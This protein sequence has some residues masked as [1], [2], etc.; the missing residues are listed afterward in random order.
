[1]AQPTRFVF[2][3]LFYTVPFDDKLSP[4]Q[5]LLDGKIEKYAVHSCCLCIYLSLNKRHILLPLLDIQTSLRSCV[6]NIKAIHAFEGRCT[7][8]VQ[9]HIEI[10]LMNSIPSVCSNQ[11][12]GDRP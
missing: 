12:L 3:M 5:Y 8:P 1:M 11:E 2:E 10:S 6:A 4:F 9:H 7:G